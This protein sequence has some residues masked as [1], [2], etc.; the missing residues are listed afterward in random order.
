MRKLYLLVLGC[1]VLVYSGCAPTVD[2]AAERTA[3]RDAER[4]GFNA[5]N[6]KD[7]DRWM[8][9]FA[10]DAMVF[11][12]GSE[13]LIGE[14]PIREWVRVAME[15]EGFSIK[16][17]NDQTEVS[18][19]G[20]LAYTQGEYESTMSDAEGNPVT[21]RGKYL[22]VWKKQADGTWKIATDIWNTN[23]PAAPPE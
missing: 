14:D 17:Q 2:L 15:S 6:E 9:V 1:L 5:L 12:P 8:N 11:P 3:V 23:A 21:E 4:E 18:S 10:A 20:D 19:G 16:Y 13:K 7:L 22:T